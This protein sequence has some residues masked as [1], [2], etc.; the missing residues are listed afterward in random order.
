MARSKDFNNMEAGR[1]TACASCE[2]CDTK[3]KCRAT[4]LWYSGY[5][6]VQDN[7]LR[8]TGKCQMYKKVEE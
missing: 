2:Y 6:D 4:S 3:P 7:A 5:H 8:Q 1:Y